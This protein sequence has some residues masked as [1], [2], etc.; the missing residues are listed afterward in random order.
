MTP[1]PPDKVL[2]VEVPK[3]AFHEAWLRATRPMH[4]MSDVEMAAAACLLGLGAP[5]L[6]PAARLAMRRALGV[7]ESSLRG[8]VM[9]LRRKGFLDGDAVSPRLAPGPLRGRHFRLMIDFVEDD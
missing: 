4:G 3:G 1:A 8:V 2:R 6:T 7:S 5:R 9:R